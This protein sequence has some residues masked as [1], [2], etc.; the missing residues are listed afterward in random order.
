MCARGGS[1]VK[2]FTKVDLKNY[3]D[4]M[5][6]LFLI[7]TK[8]HILIRNFNKSWAETKIKELENYIANGEQLFMDF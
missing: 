6:N 5:V 7:N 4:T 8:A 2:R 3:R 1:E